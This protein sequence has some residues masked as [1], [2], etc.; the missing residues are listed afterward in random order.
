MTAKRTD[1]N[2]V[3]SYPWPPRELSP[4]ARVHWAKKARIVKQYREVCRLLSKHVRHI[5][6][7]ED[8][9]S[10]IIVFDPPDNR[11][12]DTDN[13]IASVKSLIDGIADAIGR[14][15]SIFTIRYR[16]NAIHTKGGSVEVVFGV[17]D[18]DVLDLNYMF[19]KPKPTRSP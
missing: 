3:V 11:R 7:P 17:A 19:Q 2:Q 10:L 9:P 13:M 5:Y 1:R 16:K 6:R 12:R 4:N 15:D 8:R 14:D 18:D